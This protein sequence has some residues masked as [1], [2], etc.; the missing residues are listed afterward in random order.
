M[1]YFCILS[2]FM[3]ST[4]KS[5]Q[6]YSWKESVALYL[7]LITINVYSILSLCFK[8]KMTNNVCMIARYE[9]QRFKRYYSMFVQ[10]KFKS[11]LKSM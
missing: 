3:L 2:A 9:L 10:L 5:T 7:L 4:K 6:C 11:Y 8:I 1:H